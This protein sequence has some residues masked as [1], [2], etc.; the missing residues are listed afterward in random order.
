MIIYYSG[1]NHLYIILQHSYQSN[2]MPGLGAIF[3]PPTAM[4]TSQRPDWSGCP[5]PIIWCMD[6]GIYVVKQP[7]SELPLIPAA[8]GGC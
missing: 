8:D 2:K 1:G 3:R 5:S 4:T 6:H 7:E